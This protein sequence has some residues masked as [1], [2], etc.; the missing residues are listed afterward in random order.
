MSLTCPEL[1]RLP[2]INFVEALG[3]RALN[4]SEISFNPLAV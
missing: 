4:Q 1:S 2:K 3:F